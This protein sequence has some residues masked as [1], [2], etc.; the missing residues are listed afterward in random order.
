MQYTD[1][2]SGALLWQMLAVAVVAGSFY[3]RKVLFFF[4]RKREKPVESADNLSNP[5]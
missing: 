1:P 3:F 2:G 5:S 4:R